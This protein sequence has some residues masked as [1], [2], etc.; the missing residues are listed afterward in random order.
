MGFRSFEHDLQMV[1]W[2]NSILAIY[3]IAME[4]TIS[5]IFIYFW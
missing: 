2:W 3:N 1:D 5:N 4:H